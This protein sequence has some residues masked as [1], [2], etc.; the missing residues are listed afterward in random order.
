MRRRALILAT[1]ALLIASCGRSTEP[2]AVESYLAEVAAVQGEID[3]LFA[4]GYQALDS[5]YATRETFFT[6]IGAIPYRDVAVEALTRAEQLDPPAHLEADHE[7]WVEH[8]NLAV[9]IA[10]RVAAA[11]EKGDLQ[12]TLDGFTEV[13]ADWG[14][15]LN[16]WTREFCLALARSATE[17]APPEDL[18]GGDYGASIYEILRGHNNQTRSFFDF[19]PDLS[20]EE[21][22][23]RLDHVQP[24]IEESLL[25]ARD[26][27]RTTTPPREFRGDHSVIVWFFEQQYKTAVSIS[28]AN[29]DGN[30]ALVLELFERSRKTLADAIDQL[31]PAFLEFAPGM[32][33]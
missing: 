32:E 4:D 19:H 5:L 30:D 2:E 3:Q 12:Q 16:A 31:S 11:V 26:A 28:E 13:D 29:E 15:L 27:L 23:L 7:L 33:G 1:G 24:T 8:R 9:D 14:R 6:T 18:P 21:R 10:N 17:C 22:S 20:P 25:E